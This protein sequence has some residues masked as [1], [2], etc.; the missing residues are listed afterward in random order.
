MAA[1]CHAHPCGAASI[2]AEELPQ[3]LHE[4]PSNDYPITL[5]GDALSLARAADFL[6]KKSYRITQQLLLDESA[7]QQLAEAAQLESGHTVYRLWQPSPLIAQWPALAKQWQIPAGKGLDI[8][9]GAGRDLVY[10]AMQGWQMTGVDY[11]PAA[12]ARAEDLALRHSVNIRTQVMDVQEAHWHWQETFDLIVVVRYLHRSLLPKLDSLL[13]PGG[14]LLYQTFM[15]GAEQWGSPKNPNRLLKPGE[16]VAQFATY[17]ILQDA[18]VPL[19]DGRPVSA[20]IARK[21]FD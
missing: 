9:C 16:L 13:N 7:L 2:P 6:H 21:P 8:A 3:R 11:L 12:L 5:C 19:P 4:L 14:V 1:Y 18:C 15:Q 17:H 10:L 20:F